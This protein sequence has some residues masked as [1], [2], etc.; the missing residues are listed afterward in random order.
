MGNSLSFA[1]SH[2]MLWSLCC[3][4]EFVVKYDEETTTKAENPQRSVNK[5]Q[6]INSVALQREMSSHSN[7]EAMDM[8]SQ[9]QFEVLQ[10]EHQGR[11]RSHSHQS[12]AQRK[13]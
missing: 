9:L 6:S 10:Q 7:L 1:V 5:Q 8:R 3:G 2:L 12:F 11:H 4:I 13:R